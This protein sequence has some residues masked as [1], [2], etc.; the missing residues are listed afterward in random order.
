MET[1]W[2]KQA[3][4]RKGEWSGILPEVWQS[5]CAEF[6]A[7]WALPAGIRHALGA[8]RSRKTAG[9]LSLWGERSSAFSD[10]PQR[11]TDRENLAPE[12]QAEYGWG[13]S[14]RWIKAE[15]D[16]KLNGSLGLRTINERVQR[17]GAGRE[18]CLQW[19]IEGFPPVIEVDAFWI[20]LMKTTKDKKRSERTHTKGES[21]PTPI[22]FICPG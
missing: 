1:A 20:T 21:G 18:R 14:L 12:M 17:V 10:D 5:Q 7:E 4:R 2:E 11:A 9:T 3:N 22:D 13:L 16:A 15:E 19:E 8:R 6:L